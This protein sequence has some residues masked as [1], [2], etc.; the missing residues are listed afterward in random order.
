ME[1]KKLEDAEKRAT[2]RQPLG[3][4]V[5]RVNIPLD[6]ATRLFMLHNK[7]LDE[8]IKIS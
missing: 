1:Y 3:R 2:N 5:P 8:G 6:Y 7:D 4:A